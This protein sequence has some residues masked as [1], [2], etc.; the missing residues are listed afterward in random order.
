MDKD[1][2]V[3]GLG[4]FSTSNRT[5]YSYVFGLVPVSQGNQFGTSGTELFERDHGLG[6]RKFIRAEF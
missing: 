5:K 3:A 1:V 4:G 2:D 6:F